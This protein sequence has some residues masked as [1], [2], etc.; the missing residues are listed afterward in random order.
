[1]PRNRL[2]FYATLAAGFIPL[3]YLLFPNF[4]GILWPYH[5]LTIV[6]FAG[7]GVALIGL[8]LVVLRASHQLEGLT[9]R[10][11]RIP[12]LIV[13]VAVLLVMLP[14]LQAA[15]VLQQQMNALT[16]IPLYTIVLG[17]A[18]AVIVWRENGERGVMPL[19]HGRD[20]RGALRLALLF[21]LVS[22]AANY[23]VLWGFGYTMAGDSPLYVEYGRALFDPTNELPL[24]WRTL[25]YSLLVFLG[26]P[27]SGP[28]GI[29]TLQIVVS[30]SAV[31]ALVYLIARHSQILAIA[32]GLF[33]SLDMVWLATHR[34]LMTESASI[35]ML[36]LAMV[37]AVHHLTRASQ[38]RLWHLSAAGAFYAW[39]FYLR[40]SNLV[41]LGV[42][43]LAYLLVMRSGR[44]LLYL[45]V[46][47]V[48]TLFVMVLFNGWRYRTPVLTHDSAINFDGALFIVGLYDR[49]N[50]PQ[51]QRFEDVAREC[52][53][54][55]DVHFEGDLLAYLTMRD[56]Y[57]DVFSLR[58]NVCITDAIG[59]PTRVF[60][61]LM[62]EALRAD[63]LHVVTRQAEQNSA[64]FALLQDTALLYDVQLY[65]YD[66]G[67]NPPY[68]TRLQSCDWCNTAQYDA[69]MSLKTPLG[70]AL[71]AVF[72]VV[73]QPYLLWGT[74]PQVPQY[75]GGLHNQQS[76][77][78]WGNGTA[79]ALF[80][81]SSPQA[82]CD[83]DGAHPC[84]SLSVVIAWFLWVGFVFSTSRGL[85]RWVVGLAFVFI[86]WVVLS[87]TLGYYLEPRYATMF[88]PFMLLISVVGWVNIGA[89]CWCLLPQTRE[90]QA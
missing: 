56:N 78:V 63:P 81:L 70:E 22:M 2:M 54:E 19:V 14:L 57:W 6:V 90:G 35:A 59:S 75:L 13:W 44:R 87:T 71:T 42:I 43:V 37:L 65:G 40:A 16:L 28:F 58:P 3:L 18:L 39:A 21:A 61:D 74:Q 20:R 25:P 34:Y 49:D 67:L 15:N 66:V 30:A 31:F 69:Q 84:I 10:F 4:V 89:A 72:Q 48:F 80:G 27:N 68:N 55:I 62:G 23:V 85:M 24:L 1:M 79:Y 47:M 11:K 17:T 82:Y 60:S 51:S 32:V 73:R 36:M 46:G 38:V 26:L 12:R 8:S 83:A 9:K 77:I 33:L 29:L 88:A 45:V 52:I 86:H 5:A 41:L 7:L 76:V 64:A 53:P 50:G